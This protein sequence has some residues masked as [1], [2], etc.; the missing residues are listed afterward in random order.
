MASMKPLM[1]M[2]APKPTVPTSLPMY[3]MV[4]NSARHGTTCGQQALIRASYMICVPTL[5]SMHFMALSSARH[6][7]ASSSAYTVVHTGNKAGCTLVTPCQYSRVY[8]VGHD[9]LCKSI[10]PAGGLHARAQNMIAQCKHSA[11]V[12]ATTARNNTM[13]NSWA[14]FLHA[15]RAAGREL[16]RAAHV[17]AGAVD[18][19]LDGLLVLGVQVQHR[20]HQ[21]VAQLL[22]YRLAQEDDALAILRTA[23]SVS[24][25]CSAAVPRGM[26]SCQTSV[27]E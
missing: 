12:L 20:G 9:L 7:T 16:G 11:L 6:G 13:S 14:W 8:C 5:L 10:G 2:H 24:G 18:V 23:V 21:L 26:A 3:F 27:K 15:M 17:A 4:S 25:Q 19:Q 22:I 1:P